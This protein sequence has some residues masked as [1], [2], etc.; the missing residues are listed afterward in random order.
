MIQLMSNN[1]SSSF[2]NTSPKEL[3]CFA[4]N[5]MKVTCLHDCCRE[6]CDMCDRIKAILMKTNGPVLVVRRVGQTDSSFQSDKG[7][8]KK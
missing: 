5:S 6:H 3:W 4:C 2:P 7:K 8:K 1:M